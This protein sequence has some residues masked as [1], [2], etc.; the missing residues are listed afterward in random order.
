MDV[1]I[2]L[3]TYNEK[4]NIEAVIDGVMEHMKG[5]YEI[6]VVDDNSPD[7]TWKVVE[8][9][10]D[11]RVRL[12]RR[13]DEKGLASAI[14]RG[15]EASKGAVVVVMDTD[16][17]HP[18]ETLPDLIAATDNYHIARG[19]RYVEGGGMI[20]S[21]KRKLLSKMT[22][23]F[24]KLLLGFGIKDYTTSFFAARREVFEDI[25]ILDEWG[26]HGNYSIGFLYTAQKK[27]LNIK[28]VPF[29]MKDRTAGITK[30]GPDKKKLLKWGV[31]YCMTVLRLKFKNL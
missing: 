18:P 7:G 23:L 26:A 15:I 9:I 27:G 22:N 30:V 10:S 11:S 20:T 6:I 12:L 3:P 2:I 13:M 21:K 1:S 16:F 24:A 29:I 5:D 19:S 31:R 8:E 17:A 28:E 14:K 4:E 25:E